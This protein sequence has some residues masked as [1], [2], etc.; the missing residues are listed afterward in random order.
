MNSFPDFIKKELDLILS[1]NRFRS[2]KLP[3]GIDLSSNDYLCLSQNSKVKNALIAGIEFYGAGSGA[4]RLIRG[5]RDIF[6]RVE[7]KF[8]AWVGS[9]TSIFLSNG[10]AANLGLI[11]TLSDPRTIIF[12]DRLNHASILDGIRI[13]GAVKKYFRHKDMNHLQELLEKS[14]TNSRKIIVS[15]TVFSMDG[16]SAD[17]TELIRLKKEFNACLILDEAH[18]LGVFGKEG[19]GVACLTLNSKYELSDIDFRVYTGGKSLGL[20][21][22][23]IATSHLYKEYLI[24]T[25]R[26]FI[27]STAPIPA[28]AYALSTSIDLAIEMEKERTRILENARILRNGLKEIGLE[29]LSSDSQIVP[30]VLYEEALAMQTASFLQEKGFDIRA[31]RPP[32]VKESRLRIS[33]NANISK[34]VILQVLD[35]LKK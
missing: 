32:T 5:H 16:D 30:V 13:S 8:A 15:E 11:D 18:A 24:N 9:E 35:C 12:T 20:E 34:E 14:D 6:E 29:T 33:V 19:A 2:L 7:S 17:V 25:M 26:T 1:K 4:S 3:N 23:F 31:I 22:S 27:F 21:G 28:I 10:F